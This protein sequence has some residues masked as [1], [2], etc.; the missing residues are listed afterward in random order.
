MFGCMAYEFL[1]FG[2]RPYDGLDG[3][4]VV[5]RLG[6]GRLKLAKYLKD[7]DREPFIEAGAGSVMDVFERCLEMDTT[8]R[9]S[10]K[11]ISKAL[12]EVWHSLSSDLRGQLRGTPGTP[13][14]LSR[15]TSFSGADVRRPSIE[16]EYGS[17]PSEKT[18]GVSSLGGDYG[19]I[20]L[21]AAHSDSS[22]EYGGI[23]LSGAASKKADSPASEYGGIDLSGAVSKE[24]TSPASEY[25]GLDV[26]GAVDSG[27]SDG[28]SYGSF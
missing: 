12:H 4:Q 15:R 22:I 1:T 8:D 10:M 5:V 20:D 14:G 2:R 26:S 25:G 24:T 27:S 9:P 19:G 28:D 23:D 11:T 3:P 16:S 7:N 18:S 6:S 17:M 13:S 21:S